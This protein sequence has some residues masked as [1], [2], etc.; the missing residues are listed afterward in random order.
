MIDYGVPIVRPIG[1]QWHIC[2]RRNSAAYSAVRIWRTLAAE[3]YLST[4]VFVP[5]ERGGFGWTNP[6]MFENYYPKLELV[7]LR[8]PAAWYTQA[9]MDVIAESTARAK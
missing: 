7:R 8:F 3:V 1:G 6:R 4:P 9:H 2:R 5:M